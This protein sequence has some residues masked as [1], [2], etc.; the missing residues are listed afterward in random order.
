M[1]K[2]VA[3]CLAVLG[4]L[5]SSSAA[6]ADG[7]KQITLMVG[8]P[9][10]G[11]TDVLARLFA[12]AMSAR[13]SVPVIVM[14]RPGASG[15]LA[16]AEVKRAPADGSV[17]LFTNASPIVMTRS[18]TSF[19]WPSRRVPIWSSRWARACPPR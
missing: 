1:R 11:A 10:G 18:A 9:A 3:A 16:A 19:R 15:R 14:N 12:D 4:W 2:T 13:L 17:M 5:I 7:P 8:Y 6:G